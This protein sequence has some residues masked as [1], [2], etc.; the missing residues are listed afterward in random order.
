MFTSQKYSVPA[1]C[2]IALIGG[3]L[4]EVLE[5]QVVFYLELR[6]LNAAEALVKFYM[7]HFR[8]PFR[9]TSKARLSPMPKP[10]NFLEGSEK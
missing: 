10:V 3:E 1:A 2:S 9:D 7:C 5:C 8:P 6:N 4:V